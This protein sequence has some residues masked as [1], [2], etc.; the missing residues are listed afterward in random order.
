VSGLVH[1]K[2]EE[3]RLAACLESLSWCD[4][5]LVVDSFSTDRTEEIAR[6]FPNVRFVAHEYHGAAAQ[7]NWA[8]PQCRGEWVFILDAD[9]RCPPALA[10]EILER[11][12]APDPPPAFVLRRRVW[13]L[14]RRIRFCGWSRDHVARLF[15]R[16][17]AVY[18]NKRVHARLL[19]KRDGR[20]ARHA[21]PFLGEPIEHHMID[22]LAEYVERSA[23]YGR[24]AAAQAW[25]DG[26]RIRVHELVAGPAWRFFRAY[27]LNGGFLDGAHGLAFC[28]AQALATYAKWA[29]LWGWQREQALGREPDLPSF[30]DEPERW[31][32][33]KPA[34]R[35]QEGAAS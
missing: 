15:R 18:E 22:S 11:I 13:M 12:G 19:L 26:R 4:E 28:S 35:Q 21:C 7:K 2:N 30:D 31:L 25:R 6:S 27:V 34:Q 5:I 32:E 8:I 24:W 9:E 17:E 29:T 16:D 1:V 14:G 10:D 3:A 33:A 23:K 20:Q